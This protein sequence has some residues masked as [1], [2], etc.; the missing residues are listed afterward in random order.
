MRRLVL[1]ILLFMPLILLG[2]AFELPERSY[3][4]ILKKDGSASVL[5]KVTYKIKQPFRYVSWAVDFESPVAIEDVEV[6]VLRG[7]EARQIIYDRKTTRSI[8]L[9]VLFSRSMEEYLSVPKEGQIVEIAVS[10]RLRNILM[11]GKDFS[12]LYIKYIGKGTIVPTNVLTVRVVLPVEFGKPMVYHHPWGLYMSKNEISPNVYEFMF[13]NVPSD[14]FVEG[15]FVFPDVVGTGTAYLIDTWLEDVKKEERKYSLSATGIT[16]FGVAYFVIVV[17][18]PVYIYRKYGREE[19]IDYQTEYEREIPYK[20]RPELVN[21]VVKKL[22]AAP[23]EDAISAAVLDM[24]RTGELEFVQ[25]QKFEIVGVRILKEVVGRKRLIDCFMDYQTDGVIFFKEVK[26]ALSKQ[27]N[28]RKFLGKLKDWSDDIRLKLRKRNYM[29]MR[30]N[31]LA[32]GFAAIVGVL[33][34]ILLIGIFSNTLKTGFEIVLSYFCLLMIACVGA[35]VVVLLMKRTVFARWTK[36]GLLYYLRWKSFERYLTDFSVLSTY[37]PQSVAIWDEYLV[38]ATAL[39]VAKEVR[40]NLKR[41]F[42]EPPPTPVAT[43]VYHYPD[44]IDEIGSIRS[45]ALSTVSRSGSSSSGGTRIGG[46]SGGSRV[47]VG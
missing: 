17:L 30:G 33:L 19:K 32:K 37:P 42:P 2:A 28:A 41:L 40:K 34:P 13:R 35:S 29:N 47:G 26:K 36:E 45:V 43:T 18:F 31:H 4:I 7:P 46:G 22:C 6:E 1:L 24:V 5:E 27:S 3:S 12:Q 20:D 15:R 10:Y 21:A 8:S 16:V 9:K 11:E 38:Y 25:N 23:D 14:T 39:G 44:L